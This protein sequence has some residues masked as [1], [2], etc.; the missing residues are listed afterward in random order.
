[1]FV[2][3]RSTACALKG[4]SFD[5][6]KFSQEPISGFSDTTVERPWDFSYTVC[7]SKRRV[8]AASRDSGSWSL[9]WDAATCINLSIPYSLIPSTP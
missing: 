1:M 2:V 8:R 3:T 6:Q 7:S 4:E 9:S 5:R